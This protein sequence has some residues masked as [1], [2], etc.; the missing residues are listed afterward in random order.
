VENYRTRIYKEYAATFQDAKTA[1]DP[2]AAGPLCRMI[3]Y[4]FRGWFPQRQDAIIIDLACG[5]GRLLYCFKKEGF[6]NIAGVDISPDQ[7]ALS[8]QVTDNVTQANIL[9]YLQGHNNSFDLI[10]GIDIIEHFHKDEVLTFLDLCQGA[11]KPG[12]RLILQTPN[13]DSPW[14]DTLRYGDFTHEVCFNPN[15]LSRLMRLSGMKEIE[16]RETGP[17]PF[18]YSLK[19]TFR[20]FLWQLIRALLMLWNVAETGSTGSKVFTRVF[21]ISGT[22]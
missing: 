3:K 14:G 20:Y 17:V 22:K 8:R 18:G 13:A 10:T 15:S 19:S 16:S 9:D 4:S 5:G 11:L 12:G 6:G 2:Q 21:L 7:V 1:F